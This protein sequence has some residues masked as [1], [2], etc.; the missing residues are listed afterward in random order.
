MKSSGGGNIDPDKAFFSTGPAPHDEE[1]YAPVGMNDHDHDPH[2]TDPHRASIAEDFDTT[3]G[4]ASQSAYS[5]QGSYNR[6]DSYRIHDNPFD[7]D[8]P[9]DTDAEYNPRHE[10]G[11]GRLYAPPPADDDFVDDRPAQFPAGNYDRVAR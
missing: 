10:G 4:G 6:R 7:H 2:G 3:Y 8:S 9:F 11:S 1:A 5:D